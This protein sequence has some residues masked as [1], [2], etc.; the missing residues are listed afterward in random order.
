MDRCLAWAEVDRKHG[1]GPGHIVLLGAQ[2][3]GHESR[4]EA[5]FHARY[6]I[7]RQW[8]FQASALVGRTGSELGTLDTC[9]FSTKVG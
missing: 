8:K 3:T 1:I 2:P 4:Q 7:G 9:Y 5:S 6:L